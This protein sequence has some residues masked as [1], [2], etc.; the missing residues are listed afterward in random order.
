MDVSGL[1]LDTNVISELRAKRTNAHFAH[2]WASVDSDELFLSALTLGE[3]ELGIERLRPRDPDR[4]ELLSAWSEELRVGFAQRVLGV[5]SD[6]ARCWGRLSA[7]RSR[8]P[9]DTLIAATAI[10][11][12]LTLVTRNVTDMRGL[13][14][15]VI[16]PFFDPE[17]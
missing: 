5:N 15:E 7:D 11:H 1:L 14:V 9:V 8:P 10:S 2:W 12:G 6:V 13:P 16:N 17:R 3:V 4:A